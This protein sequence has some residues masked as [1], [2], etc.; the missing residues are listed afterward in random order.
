MRG[1]E[2][3]SVDL[4]GTKFDNLR[5]ERWLGRGG[6]GDVYLA[7][8]EK[9]ERQ[10]A[11]KTLRAGNRMSGHAK[12]R[13][14]REARLLSKLDDPG[15]CRI[16][17]IVETSEM[18][19]L[20]LE[21]IDGVTVRELMDEG[22]EVSRALEIIRD[23]AR[24]LAEAHMA[25]VVHRDLK[26][27]N[28][29]ITKDGH[30]K[31]LDF[32]IARSVSGRLPS[33]AGAVESLED[34]RTVE[35]ATPS[36]DET[37]ASETATEEWTI[38]STGAIL[39][40]QGQI[41]GTIHYMSPEQASARAVDEAG[42]LYALGIILQEMVSGLSAYEA[43]GG[44]E[45]LMAVMSAETIPLEDADPAVV[46]LVEA[47]QDIDGSKR[48]SA[49]ETA[50]LTQSLLDRPRTK[51]RRSWM[52]LGVAAVISLLAVTGLLSWRMARP[53]PLLPPGNG[54]RVLFLPFVNATADESLDWVEE[55]L[56][57]M[58]EESLDEVSGL[59]LP[60]ADRVREIIRDDGLTAGNLDL[61]DLR[62]LAELFGAQLAIAPRLEKR[63]G[64]YVF[65][66]RTLSSTGSSGKHSLRSDDVMKGANLLIADLMR[67]MDP[68]A[69]F[70]DLTEH[71]SADPFA[72]RIYAIGLDRLNTA[73]P[74]DALPFF[75]VDL[76]L[77]PKFQWARL[78]L[79]VCKEREGEWDAADSLVEKIMDSAK[80]N[81]ADRLMTAA[82]G[83]R[84]LLFYRRGELDSARET[85]TRAL[86][87]ARTIHD[88]RGE[89]A[90]L[91]RLGDIARLQKKLSET[92]EYYRASL[93]V[94]RSAGDRVGEAH[95]LHGLGVQADESG[96]PEEGLSYLGQA[97]ALERSLGLGALQ[98]ATLDSLGK[99]KNDQQKLNEAS[100]FFEASLKIYRRMARETKV[101][102][103]LNNLSVLRMKQNRI[104]EAIDL[105]R[106]AYEISAG[107]P[108]PETLGTR[109]FNLAYMLCLT[110]KP[111]EAEKYLEVARKSF[112]NPWDVRFIEGYI[113]AL[114]GE[115]TRALRILERVKIEA[116][117]NWDAESEQLLKKVRRERP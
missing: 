84:S 99:I 66:Y 76:N 41:V 12:E 117:E 110:A 102:Y 34:S 3:V 81:R 79:A 107:L 8:D 69:S 22:V 29:M 109:A 14:L 86:T 42:D 55:G 88:R 87:L 20:V 62:H 46:E 27:E 35:L 89:A 39:T 19:F 28:I 33:R 49:A 16:H 44:I 11:V 54:G 80:K 71:F 52:T 24:A 56:T 96:R 7:F 106:E 98:A 60:S 32:G 90:M 48:P 82:L 63:A 115:N 92:Q 36:S 113:A 57:R 1:E 83:L 37:V 26:P 40:A 73:G 30:T 25:K 105:I 97:L 50:I 2:S 85:A 77:D 58:V 45:L 114:K 21:F 64:E 108:E 67:R 78:Q 111:D 70:G 31:I 5:I 72:N 103:V 38:G 112:G 9:L 10:V 94:Y 15:I 17:N 95:S 59:E 68:E 65:G 116:G 4:I 47:L 6:M 53:R 93:E 100:A 43:Q 104:P 13:F 23:V 91:F 101:G 74:E 18:D 75:R 61:G 51:R